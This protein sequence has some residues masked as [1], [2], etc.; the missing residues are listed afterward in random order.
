MSS[1]VFQPLL[2]DPLGWK[3]SNTTYA[4]TFT[5]KNYRPTNKDKRVSKYGQRYQKQ[6]KKQQQQTNVCLSLE[7]NEE[8]TIQ[9]VIVGKK[10]GENRDPT[11]ASVRSSPWK[12]PTPPPPPVVNEG[13]LTPKQRPASINRVC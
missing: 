10:F 4:D 9:P 2:H 13:S 11:P 8:Q 3:S 6:I 12:T 1:V 7:A 5:W